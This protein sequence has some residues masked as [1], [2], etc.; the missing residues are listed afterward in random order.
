MNEDFKRSFSEEKTC[1]IS[2]GDKYSP[3]SSVRSI[4]D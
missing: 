2:C 3:K 4:L 1:K